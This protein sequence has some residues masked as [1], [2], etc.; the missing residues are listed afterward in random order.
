MAKFDRNTPF[1]DLP[2]LP[3]ASEIEHDPEILKKLVKTSRAL[4]S[5]NSNV[6]RLPNPEMLINTIA[7][8]EA[9]TST[10][11]ENIFT[12]EDELYKAI[13][14]T[15]KEENANVAIKEVLRY[16][17]QFIVTSMRNFMYAFRIRY[18][19]RTPSEATTSASH[20]PRNLI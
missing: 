19:G 9:K 13:S 6:L 12:T 20:T 5:F 1:N 2:L 4:A 15:T 14:D 8:Q 11:I 18:T 10:A 7:L 3:L 17:N 16:P